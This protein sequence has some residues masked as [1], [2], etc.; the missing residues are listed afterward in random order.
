MLRYAAKGFVPT[1]IEAKPDR[2][3][4]RGHVPRRAGRGEIPRGTELGRGH[5]VQRPVRIPDPA[6][7]PYRPAHDLSLESL[8]PVVEGFQNSVGLGASA[9]FSDPLGFDWLALDTSY[10][11]DHALP[12]KERLHFIA[13]AHAGDWTTGAAWN[14][15]DFYDLFGP[16]KRSLAGYNGYV[17][18]DRPLIYDPPQTLASSPRSPITAISTRCRAFRT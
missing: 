8:I 9:R 3:S 11:P 1:L 14:R 18:Y 12:S 10:S 5:T 13:D 15:A 16:T 17:S 7:G 2:G 6:Q 4:E